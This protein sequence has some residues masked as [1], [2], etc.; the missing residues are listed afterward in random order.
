MVQARD[1]CAFGLLPKELPPPF[2]STSFGDLVSTEWTPDLIASRHS[3]V[4]FHNLFRYG[5]LRRS[6]SIPNPVHFVMLAHFIEQNWSRL[7]QAA[8]LSP[9]SLTQPVLDTAELPR[10]AL[11]PNHQQRVFKLAKIRKR[12]GARY[13]LKA[14]VARFYSSIYTHALEWAIHTKEAVKANRRL[15]RADR[16]SF[17]GR[18]LDDLSRNLNAGQSVGLPIGPDT[19]LLASEILLSRVDQ[20][21]SDRIG[22]LNGIRYI[23]DYELYFDSRGSAEAGL[24]VLGTRKI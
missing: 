21:A 7:F 10:R 11:V 8:S 14:D 16:E 18:E 5:N 20:V 15:P 12:V 17:W 13:V 19:S 1:I 22:C 4:V 24:A 3:Q 9:W 6:I 23:D 2:S